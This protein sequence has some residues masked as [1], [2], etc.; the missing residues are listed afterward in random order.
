M[1]YQVVHAGRLYEIE[2]P[3]GSRIEGREGDLRLLVPTEAGSIAG[4]ELAPRA[5]IRA[6]KDHLYG[7]ECVRSIPLEPQAAGLAPSPARSLLALESA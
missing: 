3:T 5:L 4:P 7:L 6:A 1:R 2:A